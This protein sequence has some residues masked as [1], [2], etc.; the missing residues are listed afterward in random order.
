M[1]YCREKKGSITV[2]LA[3]ILS[4]LLSLVCTSIESVRMASART[5]ILNSMD[6]GLY[7]VF[8]QYDKKLLEEY[9]LFAL[10]GSMGGGQLNLA[11]VCDNLEAYMKPMLKQNS[12]KL[13][14][15]QSGLTGYC[16]LTD[17]NGEVFYQ[18]IVQYM[19]ETLGSQGVQI[20]LNRMSDREKKTEE[21]NLKASQAESGGSIDRYDSEMNQASQRSQQAAE[22]TSGNQTDQ[23]SGRPEDQFGSGDAQPEPVQKPVDNP[24]TIIKRIMKMGVLELILP[25]GRSLSTRE[26]NKNMLV[27]GRTLQQGMAMPYVMTAENSYTSG[28]LYQQYLMNHLSNYISPSSEGLAYQVE[29]IFAGKDNDMDNLKSVASRLL[30][31]REG[32]NFACLMADN[33]K[34]S[35]AQALAAAIA[36]GFLVPPAAVVI[37]TA[38]LLCWAFAESVLDVRELFAGGKIPLVKT[39]SDWQISLSNLGN[40]MEG[41]DTMRRNDEHGMSYE[42][43][44]QV[45][46][47]SASKEKK[48]MR[49][50]DMIENTIR[51]KGRAHFQMDSCIVAM[52]AFADVKANKKK[53]FHVIRQYCY[54]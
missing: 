51:N 12:Q 19:Q 35:E 15:E 31:I 3:L 46:L 32:V 41:L 39:S 11:K 20:L 29:Y 30:F 47:M 44:L 40:L 13:N 14:L 10:D 33:V 16:L 1:K 9:D 5:Q 37:E 17:D 24:I 6:I 36:A 22:E 2:F 43:Y 21:A 34:R 42:D 48:V 38:L 50:M 18:Q 49:G 25:S 7:S 23:G 28:V 8:G 4:L 52:E 45:L 53:E 27:S 54:E 26:I